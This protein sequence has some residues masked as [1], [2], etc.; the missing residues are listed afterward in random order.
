MS[1]R[2]SEGPRLQTLLFSAVSSHPGGPRPLPFPAWVAAVPLDRFPASPPGFPA[3]C[4][5]SVQL[6][7]AVGHM[8][9][10]VSLRPCPRHPGCCP[11]QRNPGRH[12]GPL[13][14]L[15][16]PW[17]R[18]S[19]A[20]SRLLPLSCLEQ[21]RHSATSRSLPSSCLCLGHS[22]PPG[23]LAASPESLL[24][25]HI[26]RK[27]IPP[28]YLKLQPCITSPPTMLLVPPPCFIFLRCTYCSCLTHSLSAL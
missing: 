12:H 18:S 4:S 1:A 20:H 19:H 26:L 28:P 25:C 7:R 23:W 5:Q 6:L 11:A 15:L 22:S 13:R 10:L 9:D 2:L 3:V 27:A 14:L 17:A 8:S 21:T 24:Q 16:T